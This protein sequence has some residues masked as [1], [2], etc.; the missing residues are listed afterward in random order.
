MTRRDDLPLELR[1][2]LDAVDACEQNAEA[3]VTDVS[4]QEV[5]WQQQ[6]GASW[7]IAQ[8]LDHLTRMNAFYLRGFAPLMDAAVQR[9]GSEFRGLT[10]SLVGQWFVNSQ[11]PP[12]KRKLKS[13]APT[14]PRSNLPRDGLVE[15]YKASHDVYRALVDQAAHVDVT[16][17]TGPNPFVR[18][19]RMRVSTVLKIIPAH[20]RRHL[21][22]AE[23]VKRALKTSGARE[24]R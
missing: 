14:V 15:A 24:A 20:D 9:G 21:W 5:N 16:K 22:Q 17:V 18:W 23:N 4:E 11:E 10:S 3:L 1:Q 13:P 6:A 8:C 19:I 2:L 12:V 7:S